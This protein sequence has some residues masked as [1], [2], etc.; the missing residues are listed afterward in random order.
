MAENTLTGL[1]P[2][3]YEALDVV[4][5]EYVG[6]IPAVS[7][8]A[9]ADRVKVGQDVVID[10]EPVANVGDITPA[11]AIPEPTGQTSGTETM[12]ITKSRAAEFGFVG[13]DQKGLNT[14]AG[15]M[16]VQAGKIAQAL[17]SLTNEV[18][19]DLA[20]LHVDFSRAYGTAG[21]TPF[22]TANDYTDATFVNKILVDNGAPVSDNHLVLNS[23]AAATFK[24]KQS[25]VN[26]AGTD[27]MLRQGVLLD[28]DGMPIRQSA[29]I[30]TH[31]A[32]TGASA[33]TDAA[34]Y[35]V[36]ATT[37]TLASAG[38]GTILAGD[39]IAITGD[40]EKYV[41]VT[42][43]ADVSGG[44]TVVIAA[45]GL[46]QAIVGATAI[47]VSASSARNMCFNRSA[48]Q[49]LARAPA[50]PVEG[51]QASDVMQITDPFSGMSY[52][53]SIY[54]GYRKVRFEV[55]LAWGVK[56][57]KKEHTALLLG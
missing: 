35:A 26:A 28:L 16:T 22:A 24:G 50:R 5:R 44:G 33:T 51:D 32:G 7:M 55:A 42:G 2:D 29:Q 20:A 27:S 15:Y 25:A 41:V 18:E 39:V 37:I 43:D 12:S 48:I 11:M 45:P 40:S 14:G 8:N 23:A 30:N 57:I 46:R 3:I 6:L 53:F 47:T 54:P 31:T 34:G 38:T 19:S 4:S 56:V 52:E 1:V 36:G 49:L 21:T 13:E 9:S 17:R 10:V